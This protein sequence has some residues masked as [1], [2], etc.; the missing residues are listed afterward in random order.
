MTFFLS[1][2]FPAFSVLPLSVKLPHSAS[3]PGA[4][5]VLRISEPRF[6]L[7]FP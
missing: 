2:D 1:C 4:S 5:A 3:A 7:F 6:S